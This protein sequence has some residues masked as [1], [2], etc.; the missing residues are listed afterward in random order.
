MR[1]EREASGRDDV[2]AREEAEPIA[3]GH[4]D[5]DR[6]DLDGGEGASDAAARAAA[7][8]EVGEGRAGGGARGHE[9]VGIEPL[10]LLPAGRVAMGDVRAHEDQGAGRDL[11]AAQ[12][13]IVREGPGLPLPT[14]M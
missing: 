10:G 5:E 7:E 9:A 14:T 3:L 4:L 2:G 8:G 6:L 11:V 1:T 13:I 12:L